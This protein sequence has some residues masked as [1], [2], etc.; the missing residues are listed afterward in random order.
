M[1]DNSDAKKKPPPSNTNVSGSYSEPTLW[2]SHAAHINRSHA[3]TTRA[4]RL[5]PFCFSFIGDSVVSGT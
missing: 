2:S 5:R 1:L 3:V 4:R